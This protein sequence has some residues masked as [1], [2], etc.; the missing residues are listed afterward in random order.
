MAANLKVGSRVVSEGD[1]AIMTELLAE[2]DAFDVV[3]AASGPVAG[4]EG[5][6]H[7]GVTFGWLE[8]A[9]HSC[10]EASEDKLFFYTDHG[11]VGAGHPYVGLVCGAV[12]EDALVGGGDVGVGAE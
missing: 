2:H 5:G 8:L 7:L 6:T 9:R 12:G 10:E 4:D 1:S 3:G 11:V